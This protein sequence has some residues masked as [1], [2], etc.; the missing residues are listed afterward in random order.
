[1]KR[2][3][4]RD[5]ES[6]RVNFQISKLATERKAEELTENEEEAE[7]MLRQRRFG[8]K[9]E[10]ISEINDFKTDMIV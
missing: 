2:P 5:Q 4:K 1:M 3:K 6:N 9:F 7:P 10:K 8:Q